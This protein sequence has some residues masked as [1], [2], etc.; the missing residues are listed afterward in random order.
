MHPKRKL[1]LAE[2]G[3]QLH[4]ALQA[5]VLLAGQLVLAARWLVLHVGHVDH[6]LRA[7]GRLLGRALLGRQTGVLELGGQPLVRLLL[8]EGLLALAANA[9]SSCHSSLPGACAFATGWRLSSTAFE[10]E[11]VMDG[12][13]ML[14]VRELV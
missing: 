7:G 13:R 3:R 9:C 8:V 6:G 10:S 11:P 1:R 14:L 12:W 4:A 5:L 2:A